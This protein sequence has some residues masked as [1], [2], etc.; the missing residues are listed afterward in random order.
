[1]ASFVRSAGGGFVRGGGGGRG[2]GGA[3]AKT[4]DTVAAQLFLGGVPQRIPAGAFIFSLYPPCGTFFF[5]VKRNDA[6]F[7]PEEPA[8]AAPSARPWNRTAPFELWR[9]VVFKHGRAS[10]LGQHFA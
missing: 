7:R 8:R 3:R 5:C 1:M 9:S 2:A 6:F 10:R 4:H